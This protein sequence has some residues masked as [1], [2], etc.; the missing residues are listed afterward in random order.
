MK[1]MVA[2][3]APVSRKNK[4]SSLAF[5]NFFRL[6]DGPG[7]VFFSRQSGSYVVFCPVMEDG[8]VSCSQNFIDGQKTAC[9]LRSLD[10]G[11]FAVELTNERP[12]A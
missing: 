2:P 1:Q 11:I 3:E 7:D 5:G 8:K 4:L 10:L 6:D 9:V 12:S